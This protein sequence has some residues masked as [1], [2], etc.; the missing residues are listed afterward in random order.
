MLLLAAVLLSLL[1]QKQD[2]CPALPNT[3]EITTPNIPPSGAQTSTGPAGPLP[4]I[5]YYT[6]EP[7]AEFGCRTKYMLVRQSDGTITCKVSL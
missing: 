7:C 1:A 2:A 6:L 4:S 5:R 3:E